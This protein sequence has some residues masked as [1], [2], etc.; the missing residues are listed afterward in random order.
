MQYT[1]TQCDRI[2]RAVFAAYEGCKAVRIEPSRVSA[3]IQVGSDPVILA[4]FECGDPELWLL[5]SSGKRPVPHYPP[6]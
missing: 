6:M 5:L 3:R 2:T 1:Q 4:W